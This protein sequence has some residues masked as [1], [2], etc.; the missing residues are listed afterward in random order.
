VHKSTPATEHRI[1]K[2][3]FHFPSHELIWTGHKILIN[4]A[5]IH[6]WL[7]DEPGDKLERVDLEVQM[8]V[9]LPAESFDGPLNWQLHM[10]DLAG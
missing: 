1:I 9:D 7:L 3:S 8:T 2:T 4:R 5:E 10:F 6:S